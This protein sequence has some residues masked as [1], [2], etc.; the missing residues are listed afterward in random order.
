MR[1]VRF[2]PILA[3]LLV[4]SV[5]QTATAA[6]GGSTNQLKVSATEFDPQHDCD[7]N[8]AWVKG[9]GVSSANDPYAYGLR[10]HKLCST[11][12]NAAAFGV[13]SGVK[14]ELLVSPLGFD[15]KNSN[16][17]FDAHCGAGA[18]RFNVTM[19]DGSFHFVGG[20]S[21]GTAIS[22]SP[23]A[24]TGWTQVRIDPQSAVQSFRQ[25]RRTPPS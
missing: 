10:M 13:I 14:G 9:I 12:T 7:A 17:G 18:P 16:A 22:P 1:L 23:L 3:L 4:G 19:S 24:G 6:R 20:C 25:C 2:A 5:A 11:D 8:A 21:N 15:Y